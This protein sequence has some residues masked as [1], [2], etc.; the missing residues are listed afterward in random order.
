MHSFS[1]LSH[2][3]VHV[4]SEFDGLH[5]RFVRR[6]GMGVGQKANEQGGM[7]CKV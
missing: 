3:R 7:Y 5:D 6:D 4:A 2:L 1:G